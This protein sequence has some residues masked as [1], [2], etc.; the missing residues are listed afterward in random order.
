MSGVPTNQSF[1]MADKI[2]IEVHNGKIS[3][4]QNKIEDLE[5]KLENAIRKYE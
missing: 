2:P 1:Y 3:E 4:L 5:E